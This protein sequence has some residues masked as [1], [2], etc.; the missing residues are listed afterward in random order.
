VLVPFEHRDLVAQ[1]RDLRILG[2]LARG[3]QP[4]QRERVGHAG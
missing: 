2:A 1:G 4:Q 3:L